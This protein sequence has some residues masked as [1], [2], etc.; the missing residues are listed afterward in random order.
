VNSRVAWSETLQNL[1]G[2][3]PVP[4]RSS[5]YVLEAYYTYWP[6][7]GLEVRPNIQYIIAPGGTSQNKGRARV[8][9]EDGGQFL[10]C[11]AL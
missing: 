4:I 5:E 8:W 10:S 9:P 6:L 11:S 3:G 1:A 7:A 2:L